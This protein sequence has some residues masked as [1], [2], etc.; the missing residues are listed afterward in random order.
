MKAASLILFFMRVLLIQVIALL[1][2]YYLA[3]QT[4]GRPLPD[5][6]VVCHKAPTPQMLGVW[7]DL[8]DSLDCLWSSQDISRGASYSHARI[9]SER[10]SPGFYRFKRQ[11]LDSLRVVEEDSLVLHVVEAP[12]VIPRE[13]V[14]P[15]C[16]NSGD[17]AIRLQAYPE[18]EGIQYSWNNGE[19]S[20]A[21]ERLNSGTYEVTVSDKNNCSQKQTF[22]LM[23]PEPIDIDLLLKEDA[24][25]G[26]VNGSAVVKASGGV[27][28]FSYIWNT[29]E[30]YRG[31]GLDGL[32]PGDYV[33]KA[34]DSR[35]CW[36]TLQISIKDL[37]FRKGKI[38]SIPADT[39]PLCV[40]QATVSFDAEDRYADRYIWDFGDSTR[41]E[42]LNPTHTFTAPGIY[43][44]VC[45]MY[46]LGNDCPA[47]DSLRFEIQ[48]N[49]ELVIPELFS[50]NGDGVNDQ[51][52]VRGHVQSLEM[53]IFQTNGKLVKTINSPDEKWNGRNEEG[54]KL[55]Q[56]DYLYK[57]KAELSVCEDLEQQGVVKLVR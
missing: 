39:L 51:F 18:E 23:S 15:T 9:F 48:H 54:R 50:P 49:G 53:Q 2:P 19:N 3:A 32:T 24:S 4:T 7:E 20:P 28:D 5:T 30:G 52:Y 46:E 36:D 16:D 57:V 26:K 31:V 25:C 41:S 43:S 42:S 47:K 22:A 6:L 14:I 12:R 44:V 29:E 34:E 35:G 8:P 1:F 56:G 11:I 33:V 13:I 37:P 27:G 45:T 17:G 10:L 40:S 21:L 38:N 55:A